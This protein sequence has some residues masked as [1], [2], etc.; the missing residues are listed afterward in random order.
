MPL[1]TRMFLIPL[2]LIAVA[3][4]GAIAYAQT[5]NTNFEQT[6]SAS[7]KPNKLKGGKPTPIALK[8]TTGAD[9]VPPGGQPPTLQQAQIFFPNAAVANGR[10][11]PSCTESILLNKGPNKCPKQSKIGKGSAIGKVGSLEV[12]TDVTAF[13]GPKGKSVLLYVLSVPSA[14]VSIRGVLNSPL[15]K[16][17]G[18]YGYR[19]TVPVPQ[20]IQTP[21]PGLHT[22][23]IF[24]TTTVKASIKHKGRMRG[25]IEA[26]KC[27]KGGKAPTRGIFSYIEVPDKTVD[28]AISCRR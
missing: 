8:V 14:P 6:L 1:N 26:F 4:G 9:T 7:V 2:A 19:L 27:P 10:F 28:T 18:K 21:L 11:F 22:G 20:N 15:K 3:V 12:K 13:N 16:L 25:Y 24:F 17:H 5:V 23:V